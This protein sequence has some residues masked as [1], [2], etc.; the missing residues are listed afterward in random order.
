MFRKI[1]NEKAQKASVMLPI[2]AYTPFKE[3]AATPVLNAG[4]VAV[5][6]DTKKISSVTIDGVAVAVTTDITLAE[7]SKLEAFIA[8][9]L[10][11]NT[12][13]TSTGAVGFQKEFDFLVSG[14]KLYGYAQNEASIT[15]IT[16]EDASDYAFSFLGTTTKSVANFSATVSAVSAIK[17]GGA[18]LSISAT[19]ASTIELEIVEEILGS[20]T[21][22]AAVVGALPYV[23][24]K[25]VDAGFL[26]QMHAV[27][28]S[29]IEIND[30]SADIKMAQVGE[31]KQAAL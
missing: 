6:D 30:G 17:F 27:P 29:V 15:K 23:S 5:A 2:A 1:A 13:Y 12:A 3:N 4:V 16:D 10:E 21:F 11:A 26:V 28:T 24:V 31:A 19:T 7:V 8:N 9:Y 20:A 22:K 25:A 18:T 14:G